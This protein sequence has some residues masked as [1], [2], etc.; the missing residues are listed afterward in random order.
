M[1]REDA[2]RDINGRSL[3]DFVGLKVSRKA[4]PNM[5]I[6][7][8]CGSGSGKNGTGAFHIY[9]D[10]KRVFCHSQNCFSEKGE[11]TLGALKII[12]KCDETEALERAGYVIDKVSPGPSHQEHKEHQ[13]HVEY[14]EL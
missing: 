14:Q 4:G 10:S 9:P 12:W 7:P 11:D 1:L 5:Y 3:T 6:C 2:R 8:I 13:E